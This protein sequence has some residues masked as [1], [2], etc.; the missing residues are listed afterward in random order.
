M[1]S[2]R[3]RRGWRRRSSRDSNLSDSFASER[4]CLTSPAGENAGQVE[5]TTAP[6]P[7]AFV[8]PSI[9]DRPLLR[10]GSQEPDG[11]AAPMSPRER[12]CACSS[13]LSPCSSSD[14]AT[15]RRRSVRGNAGNAPGDSDLSAPLC[16]A[17]DESGTQERL[18]SKTA[19]QRSSLALSASSCSES[20]SDLSDGPP[21]PRPPASV[22]RSPSSSWAPTQ[23]RVS[24]WLAD[25]RWEK[26]LKEDS[27]VRTSPEADALSRSSSFVFVNA[28]LCAEVAARI[29]RAQERA[30]RLASCGDESAGDEAPDCRKSRAETPAEAHDSESEEEISPRLQTDERE[31]QSPAT[32]AAG[33]SLSSSASVSPPL[34]R[35]SG[36]ERP[37]ETSCHG[38]SS[39]LPTLSSSLKEQ[40]FSAGG[41]TTSSKAIPPG[42]P[43]EARP[44]LASVSSEVSPSP[45][46]AT[47]ELPV[48]RDRPGGDFT[49][50]PPVGE[51]TT[52]P[53]VLSSQPSPASPAPRRDAFSS[54]SRQFVSSPE[55]VSGSSSP[56]AV[57]S[58]T[59][60]QPWC[61]SEASPATGASFLSSVFSFLPLPMFQEATVHQAERQGRSIK[62][63]GSQARAS[64]Q[65]GFD[66]VQRSRRDSIRRGDERCQGLRSYD[67][68]S[69]TSSYLDASRRPGCQK[70]VTTFLSDLYQQTQRRSPLPF[71]LFLRRSTSLFCT[72]WGVL[73]VV[74]GLGVLYLSGKSQ[75]FVVPYESGMTTTSVF[76]VPEHLEAPVFV[77]YRITDFYGNYRPYLKD[78]PESVSTSYKC[79]IILSQREALDFR[80]FN[81]VLTLP[82]LRR[83]IDGK[84]IPEDS[85]RAFPC[86][87]QS[88]SLF[89]D[90][91]SVHRVVANCAEEDLS[92]STDDIAY[93]WDFTRFMVRNSTWEKL[94]AMP[95]ILPSDDRFRVWLHPPFTPSFQKLYGVINTSLEPDNSYFLRFSES[96]W[97]AEQWQATKAIVFV[98][99][100]PVIGG[101]NYPLAYACLATGG[102][103]LLGVILL[104]LFYWCGLTFTSRTVRET[105]M[106]SVIRQA[107]GD[108]GVDLPGAG[109]GGGLEGPASPQAAGRGG[110]AIS[111]G[112]V[113]AAAPFVARNFPEPIA[114]VCPFHCPWSEGGKKKERRERLRGEGKDPLLQLPP[115]GL[116]TRKKLQKRASN[117]SAAASGEETSQALNSAEENVSEL[118]FPSG[119]A[120]GPVFQVEPVEETREPERD[121]P[122]MLMSCLSEFPQESEVEPAERMEKEENEARPRGI[123]AIEESDGTAGDALEDPALGE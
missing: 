77:Y 44:F 83:S 48:S 109:R 15:C 23:S 30:K 24:S 13:S 112:D 116:G 4:N 36:A 37:S 94:D 91:F 106:E 72:C 42:P 68:E 70:E 46:C 78:G 45:S 123:L 66:S 41:L 98:S 53:A 18:H 21:S 64:L 20:D 108:D 114:C 12:P 85:P 25:A 96:Q 82:T 102:F 95:W 3:H 103:C 56:A 10:R 69:D 52:L 107:E 76:Q 47:I 43:S 113:A 62:S 119:G 100:A 51:V 57:R 71:Q 87:L 110:R 2:P 81:G 49:L 117:A 99:L 19:E 90:K 63:R 29:R 39:P 38:D 75:E 65:G 67:D 27:I 6:K 54:W 73:L 121:R 34:K 80:T 120:Q 105:D 33:P 22:P 31:D 74:L 55:G 59:S 115:A 93:H 16:E 28:E 11:L 111:G 104:W 58:S 5:A 9:S 40:T 118:S 8:S 50:V 101:A 89:N 26:K 7:D 86:G 92:I 14:L 32:E 122:P 60:P 84:P 97:P 88:L 79:D 35:S 61:G 17:A 1:S